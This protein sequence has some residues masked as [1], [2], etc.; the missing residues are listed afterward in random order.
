M[1]KLGLGGSESTVTHDLR[2]TAIRCKNKDWCHPSVPSVGMKQQVLQ[3]AGLCYSAGNFEA[4]P[5]MSGKP[6]KVAMLASIEHVE[7][8]GKSRQYPK[9]LKEIDG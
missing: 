4:G 9:T 2:I 3:L 1:N 6:G 8:V 7:H 5:G